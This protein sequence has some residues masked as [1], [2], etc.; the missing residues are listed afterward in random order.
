MNIYHKKNI[1]WAVWVISIIIV[2]IAHLISISFFFLLGLFAMGFCLI[3]IVFSN[4]SVEKQIVYCVL[5]FALAIII[6]CNADKCKNCSG[7][8]E[9]TCSYC[10]GLYKW[11]CSRCNGKGKVPGLI[12]GTNK[13]PSCYGDGT[14]TC[15]ECSYGKIKC[16]DC[17]GT[18]KKK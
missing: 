13:C 17:N 7:K 15:S 8:G 11:Q 1:Y 3:S 12:W 5:T 14:V 16:N 4:I 9:K 6:S 10:E 2:I 18:G